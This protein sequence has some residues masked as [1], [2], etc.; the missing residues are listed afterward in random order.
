M[1]LQESRISKEISVTR[2]SEIIYVPTHIHIHTFTCT[3]KYWE[4]CKRPKNV[5]VFR[6]ADLSRNKFVCQK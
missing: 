1:I 2:A 5:S 6:V 4:E 3:F